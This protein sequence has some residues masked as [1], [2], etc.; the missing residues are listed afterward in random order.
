MI[1]VKVEKLDT[2]REE[3]VLL[4][5]VVS[6]EF[7]GRVLNTLDTT[8]FS[9]KASKTVAKW[10]K[11]YYLQYNETPG[12]NLNTIFEYSELEFSDTDRKYIGGL[13]EKIGE[14]SMSVANE[15]FNVEYQVDQAFQFFKSRKLDKL[16][17]KIQNDLLSGKVDS[18]EDQ[19]MQYMKLDKEESTGIDLFRDVDKL[20]IMGLSDTS[21]L[22]TPPGAFG[23]LT[24]PVRRGDFFMFQAQAKAGKTMMLQQM[25]IW[26]ALGGHLNVL[27][28]SLEMLEEAVKDR[29]Y[30]AFT[31]LPVS[32]YKG[33]KV[34]M[35]PYFTDEGTIEYREYTPELLTA[36]DIVNKSFDLRMMS[37]GGRIVVEARPQ[38]VFTEHD[39]EMLLDRYEVKYGI[40]FDV[41]VVDYPDL[42]AAKNERLEER[43][44][45]NEIYKSLRGLSQQRGCAIIAVSQGNRDSFKKG[46]S[47][48]TISEDIRKLATVT[49]AF[50]INY[51][52]DEK[53]AKYWRLS[54]IVMRNQQFNERDTVICLNCLDISRMVI[55]SRW[56]DDTTVKKGE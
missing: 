25:A 38:G 52:D 10:C 9:S 24:G 12:N 23:E 11:E 2:K 51:T 1:D 15:S 6:S 56:I 27:H 50:A 3:R 16:I 18:A 20:S 46:S 5:M 49:A 40:L 8:L 30:S 39:L 47:A 42:L 21:V 44:K 32:Y 26:A 22:F 7:M 13:L 48:S 33:N 17:G 31:G 55:D 41:V 53:Q 45:L 54:P 4:A 36:E 19:V 29:Y 37:K 34:I 28:L 14:L 35:V 43:H